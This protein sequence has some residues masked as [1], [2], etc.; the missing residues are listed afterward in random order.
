MNFDVSL[1]FES[2]FLFFFA[3]LRVAV[4]IHLRINMCQL[5][6]CGKRDM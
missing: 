2:N 1:D 4:G 5:S 6:T 3:F